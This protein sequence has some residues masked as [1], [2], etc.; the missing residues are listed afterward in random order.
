VGALVGFL[1]G[2]PEVGIAGPRLE[3]PDGAVQRSAFRFPTVLGEL[4]AGL[5]LG[6]ATRLLARRVIAPPPPPA[7]C[8]V[9]WASGACLLVRRAVFDAIGLL[10]EGYFMYYEEVDFCRRAARAGWPCWYVPAARVV[11][12]VGQ[13]GG[14]PT[15]EAPRRR[16]PEYWFRSRRRYLRAHLG[17]ARAALADLAWAAGFASFRARQ[18][19]Q[20]KPDVDPPRLLRDFARHALSRG[21][22]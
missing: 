11:H 2:R 8:R 17:P 16:M 20:R 15:P 5:R 22:R 12:L 10:D 13:S 3:D 9:E 1:E 19:L 7:A 14:A 21:P 18:R 4:E 6:P